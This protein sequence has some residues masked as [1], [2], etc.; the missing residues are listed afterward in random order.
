M[1]GLVY[2]YGAGRSAVRERRLAGVIMMGSMLEE[3]W[4]DGDVGAGMLKACDGKGD[5]GMEFE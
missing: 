4:E 2:R 5:R 3:G 1:G